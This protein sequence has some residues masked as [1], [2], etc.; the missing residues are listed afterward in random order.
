MKSRQKVRKL[1]LV[2]M[3]LFL[4]VVMFYFSPYLIIRGAA[5][6]IV[7]G[8][9]I[10][11]ASQFVFSLF[12]GRF[13]CG[14]V[15]PTGGLQECLML[16]NCK[17]AK[18]GKRNL[19]KYF[20]WTPWIA[21]IAILFVRAGGFTRF[22]FTFHVANGVSLAEPFTYFIYYGVVLIIVVLSLTAGSR[23]TC[24][25]ICWMAPFMVIGTKL[26]DR[27][28]IPRLHL[29]SEKDS[30]IGCMKCSEKCPMS[31]DVKVMVE[32]EKMKNPECILCGECID[33]CPKKTIKYAFK[34]GPKG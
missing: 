34:S 31:L 27:L 25:Y 16:A 21:V 30:C 2:I 28:K 29:E 10:M 19:I 6:G 17:K 7:T 3:F 18:G 13:F 11:F 20:I 33:I 26:A 15:C 4:P 24:H 32:T 5:E 23:A 12:F 1:L 22:D 9:V 8:S 14:Y